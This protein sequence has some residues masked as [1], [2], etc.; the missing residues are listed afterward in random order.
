MRT[1]RC[2]DTRSLFRG[3]QTT[4]EPLMLLQLNDLVS[5]SFDFRFD[6]SREVL[7]GVQFHYDSDDSISDS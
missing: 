7:F 4:N 5:L 1:V 6:G 2:P 3:L